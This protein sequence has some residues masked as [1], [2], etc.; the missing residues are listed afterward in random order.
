MFIYGQCCG[1]IW[2]LLIICTGRWRALSNT[3]FN[4]YPS[5]CLWFFEQERLLP[6]I[7]NYENCSQ[8]QRENLLPVTAWEDS[9]DTGIDSLG[10]IKMYY[11]YLCFILKCCIIPSEAR[12]PLGSYCT[13]MAAHFFL[14]ITLSAIRALQVNHFSFQFLNRLPTCYQIYKA[15]QWS[16][17]LQWTCW[18]CP[19]ENSV[20]L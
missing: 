18:F 20:P 17:L 13:C 7:W 8:S 15:L 14:K 10:V 19:I 9:G 3:L 1:I 5:L 12:F 6:W 16:I 11:L 4:Q 2:L